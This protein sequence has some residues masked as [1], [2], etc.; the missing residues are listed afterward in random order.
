MPHFLPLT[1]RKQQRSRNED[2]PLKLFYRYARL[3]YI[4]KRSLSFFA[5]NPVFASANLP[6]LGHSITNFAIEKAS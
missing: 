4:R 2:T 6:Q 5:K 1:D 3:L